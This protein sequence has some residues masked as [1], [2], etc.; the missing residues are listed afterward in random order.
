[1]GS[2]LDLKILIKVIRLRRKNN[3]MCEANEVLLGGIFND[4]KVRIDE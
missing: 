2:Y 3:V 1:M 4:S